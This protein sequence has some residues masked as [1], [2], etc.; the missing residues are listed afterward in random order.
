MFQLSHPKLLYLLAVL[1][2]IIVF[3][4]ISVRKKRSLLREFGDQTIVRELMPDYSGTRPVVKLVFLLVALA[5]FILGLAG[6][7]FGSKLQKKKHRGV[8]IMIA[9]DVSNSMLAEDIQPSRLER[10]KQA[11]SKLVDDLQDDRIGLIVFAGEAYT[12]LPITSD[13][14]SAKM[15]LSTISTNS[16]PV[17]GTAIGAA[18]NLAA[19]SFT[20]DYKGDKAIILIT[21]GEN[22]QDDALAAAKAAAEK[23]IIVHTIGM[24]LP[25]GAPIPIGGSGSKNYLKDNQGN[26]VISKLDETMLSEIAAAGNGLYIRANNTQL[27]LNTVFER[28]KKMSK[29]E[30]ETKVYAEYENQFQWPIGFALI[31]L[32]FEML[33]LDRKTKWSEKFHLFKV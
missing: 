27:G 18:I 7:E 20:P 9:L 12:Q 8:E 16:V 1:P 28:I 15:F 33:I 4:W 5:F 2:I 30:F 11:I 23:G 26:V 13:Y 3:Y 10:A 32:I 29:A 17:Q 22:H 21:D 24:G 6:P 19:R 14:I 31:L 25:E